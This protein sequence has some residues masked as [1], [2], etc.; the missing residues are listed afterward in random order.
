MTT[1]EGREAGGR[2]MFSW[3][4]GTFPIFIAM[5]YEDEGFHFR[6]MPALKSSPA[7]FTAGL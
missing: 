5:S 2:Q 4:D 1:G 6:M 7:A 3:P